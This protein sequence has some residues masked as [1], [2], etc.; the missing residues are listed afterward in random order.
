MFMYMLYLSLQFYKKEI[1]WSKI[2]KRKCFCRCDKDYL[3]SFMIEN[4]D[5]TKGENILHRRRQLRMERNR[6]YYEKK[7]I[8]TNVKQIINKSQI[9]KLHKQNQNQIIEKNVWDRIDRTG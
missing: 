1:W 9:G 3:I 4:E 7:G 6:R 2:L 5:N 8:V